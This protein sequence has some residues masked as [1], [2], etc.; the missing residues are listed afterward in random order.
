MEV[1]EYNKGGKESILFLHGANTGAWMWKPNIDLLDDFHCIAVDLPGHGKSNKLPWTSFDTIAG[2][3]ADIIRTRA[4]NGVANLV[5]LSL[6]GYIVTHLLKSHSEL[7]GQAMISGIQA[8]R[9]PKAW[10]MRIFSYMLA[11]FLKNERLIKANLAS[12]NV[13]EALTDE[14][15]RNAK[16]LSTRAF[17]R[18]TNEALAFEAPVEAAQAN[19]PTLFVAGEKEHPMILESLSVYE[20]QFIRA[21]SYIVKGLGHGWSIEDPQLFSKT[22]RN[23]LNSVS[24]PS[25]LAPIEKPVSESNSF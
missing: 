23:W 12:L 4:R 1:Y 11:P 5:G 17:L 13:P 24:L 14:Y 3:I 9:I 6:G 15:T 7:V 22:I 2:E 25:E 20:R 10:L 19:V 16:L 8:D 21:N 18:I